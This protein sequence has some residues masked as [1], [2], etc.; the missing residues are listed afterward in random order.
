MQCYLLPLYLASFIF[1][2]FG[3]CVRIC[4]KGPGMKCQQQILQ[5]CCET[6]RVQCSSFKYRPRSSGIRC[7][8]YPCFAIGSFLFSLGEI[9]IG[10][11]SQ[12]CES[13]PWHKGKH[14]ELDTVCCK[15]SVIWNLGKLPQKVLQLWV[16]VIMVLMN[17]FKLIL[18]NRNEGITGLPTRSIGEGRE[19]PEAK[20]VV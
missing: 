6:I 9:S 19:D 7:R 14:W 5:T 18:I 16:S 1:I 12:K 17:L 8:V 11:I 13:D 15:H 3:R 20:E 10:N 2:N 4:Q